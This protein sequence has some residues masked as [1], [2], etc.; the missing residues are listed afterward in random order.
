MPYNI[1]KKPEGYFVYKIGADGKPIGKARNKKPYPSRAAAKP[2][3]SALYAHEPKS[4][5]LL[6]V[7]LTPE[8]ID[9]AAV[10]D[11]PFLS[12]E[13]SKHFV[14]NENM[15]MIQK[16]HDLTS[17]LGAKCGDDEEN[18]TSETMDEENNNDAQALHDKCVAMGAK[19]KKEK[20]GMKMGDMMAGTMMQP[21]NV[22][23]PFSGATSF[24]D[25]E[26]YRMALHESQE[27]KELAYDFDIL[28]SNIM[29]NPVIPDKRSALA[30]LAGEFLDR[31]SEDIDEEMSDGDEQKS[32]NE[33]FAPFVITNDKSRDYYT[34]IKSIGKDRLGSYAILWG[35]ESV[36]DL[37][38]EYF[39]PNT[40][41]LTAIFDGIG[42]LPMLY[43]HSL[44]N[45]MKSRIVGIVDTLIKDDVG[46]WYEAQQ[47]MSDEYDDMIKK[48]ILAGKLKTSTQTFPVARRVNLKGYIERWPIV[49]ITATP[50]PAEPRMIPVSVL[51]SLYAEI[52]CTDFGC[53]L[54]SLGVDYEA[55]NRLELD[56]SARLPVEADLLR[57]AAALQRERVALLDL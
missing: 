28:V 47:K 20:M 48:L 37:T 13:L 43:Q 22:Y 2:Y 39:D 30:E 50:T 18:K 12:D 3:L 25:L 33:I 24:D 31:V 19:C 29:G 36:K 35:S 11:Q 52:G 38:G 4:I 46:L 14:G 5:N 45:V 44:D 53:V 15:R 8:L 10:V 40:E 55:L 32:Q 56:S 54:K 27:L 7:P 21:A 6:G 57:I 26:A 9:D 49:E 17:G 42:R 41:E 34:T 23:L 16:M 51:K 1:F